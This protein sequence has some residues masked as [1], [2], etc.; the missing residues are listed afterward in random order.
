M[1]EKHETEMNT[2][3]RILV[4]KPLL[5][6]SGGVSLIVGNIP[7]QGLGNERVAKLS[8]EMLIIKNKI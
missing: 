6:N 3:S 8:N 5:G 1:H 7:K 4:P 2:Q